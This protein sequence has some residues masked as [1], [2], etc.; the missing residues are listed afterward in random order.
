MKKKNR[1]SK[2]L[3][4]VLVLSLMLS[5][6]PNLSV[7]AQEVSSKEQLTE[8]GNKTGDGSMS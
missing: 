4:I 5:A 2:I 6:F 7:F 1:F 3:A 8:K